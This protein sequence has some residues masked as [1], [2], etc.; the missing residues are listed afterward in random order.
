MPLQW[1]NQFWQSLEEGAGKRCKECRSTGRNV[2]GLISSQ[3]KSSQVKSSQVSFS[4]SV[5][6]LKENVGAIQYIKKKKT[7]CTLVPI[8]SRSSLVKSILQY[9]FI[10]FEGKLG[11]YTHTHAHTHTHT[12]THIYIGRNQSSR[13]GRP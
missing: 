9:F 12:H 4:I 1:R 3:A 2:D 8:S 13:P 10:L 5:F 6:H 11:C 7:T